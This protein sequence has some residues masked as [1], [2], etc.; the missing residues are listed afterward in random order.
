MRL[1]RTGF[2]GAIAGVVLGGFVAAAGCEGTDD[3]VSGGTEAEL[4]GG[5][6]FHRGHRGHDAGSVGGGAAGTTGGAPGVITGGTS[7]G[8]TGTNGVTGADGGAVADCD[9]CTQAQQCCVVV[10][11]DQPGCTFSAATCASETGDARPAY[12]NAC[13]VYLKAVRGVWAVPPAECR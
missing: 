9:I 2:V 8:G 11:G 3:P 10:Q 7:G 13:L 4:H 6:G 12:I 5:F 1:G